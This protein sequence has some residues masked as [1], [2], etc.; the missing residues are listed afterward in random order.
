MLMYEL[1][2]AVGNGNVN[3]REVSLAP[4]VETVE[5]A[6][7]KIDATNSADVPEISDSEEE[8]KA[9]TEQRSLQLD[10]LHPAERVENPSLL[11]VVEAKLDNVHISR[12]SSVASHSTDDILA[13]LE[14]KSTR[15]TSF[16]S[17]HSRP[18]TPI[19]EAIDPQMLPPPFKRV[20][21]D[22]TEEEQGI[23]MSNTDKN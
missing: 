23:V 21:K 17:V 7:E 10:P 1:V 15:S 16:S 18:R 19:F 3:A 8:S 6:P 9:L 11:D 5:I 22:I 13:D 2:E 20:R 4:T 14:Q 12:A